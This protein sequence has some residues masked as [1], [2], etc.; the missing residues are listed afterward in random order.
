MEME[1]S[2][3]KNLG[4]NGISRL[5]KQ[6]EGIRLTRDDTRWIEVQS[7]SGANTKGFR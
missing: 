4:V 2:H 1:A 5:K 6:A 3:E 7:Y